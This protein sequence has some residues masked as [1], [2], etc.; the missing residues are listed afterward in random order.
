VVFEEERTRTQRNETTKQRNKTKQNKTKQNKAYRVG[1]S[2]GGLLACGCPVPGAL[3]HAEPGPLFV[4][5]SFDLSSAA[6]LLSFSSPTHVLPEQRLASSVGESGLVECL[7]VRRG[8]RIAGLLAKAPMSPKYRGGHE[9]MA[10]VKRVLT[11][12]SEASIGFR[13]LRS[14]LLSF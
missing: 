14:P 2:R 9:A 13:G 8:R 7:S 3:S 12:G 6:E 5:P 1:P 4:P 10:G 11:F